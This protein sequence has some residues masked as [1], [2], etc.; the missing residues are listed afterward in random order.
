M[1]ALR[2]DL[3]RALPLKGSMKCRVLIVDD[4]E[5][6]R[7]GLSRILQHAGFETVAVTNGAEAL[8][9]LHDGNVADAIVLDAVMPTMDGWTFRRA[10]LADPWIADIPVVALTGVTDHAAVGLAANTTFHKPLDVDRFVE[11]LHMICHRAERRH[12]SAF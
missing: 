10:Q 2:R 7:V 5:D 8:A 3:A 6:T 11:T 9:F 4:C 1:R 12:Q